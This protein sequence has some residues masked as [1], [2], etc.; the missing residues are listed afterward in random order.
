MQ[1]IIFL[2][3]VSMSSSAMALIYKCPTVEQM[4]E[5]RAKAGN[6]GQFSFESQGLNF[7][8]QNHSLDIQELKGITVSSDLQNSE[9]RCDYSTL[10]ARVFYSSTAI[11]PHPI[12]KVM[13][14]NTSS[15]VETGFNMFP[16][17]KPDN[18][19]VICGSPPVPY[20]LNKDF[21]SKIKTHSQGE[22]VKGDVDFN[23]S[24]D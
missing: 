7:R 19:P 22:G 6:N 1:R 13:N 8:V 18:C 16:C 21:E 17:N 9:V 24:K 23:F 3:M 4:Q 12:C 14:S 15:F 20:T 10:N 2:M 5:E 11:I